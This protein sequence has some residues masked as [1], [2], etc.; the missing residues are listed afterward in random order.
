MPSHG[1]P[2]IGPQLWA[3]LDKSALKNY[4][5]R[6]TDEEAEAQRSSTTSPRP[7]SE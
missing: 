5:P 4:Y 1:G 2:G 6:L 3:L 7:H